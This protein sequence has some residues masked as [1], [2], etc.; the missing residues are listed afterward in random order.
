MGWSLQ[1]FEKGTIRLH[2]VLCDRHFFETS[3]L[4]FSSIHVG[5]RVDGHNN[6]VPE[7][8]ALGEEDGV[9]MLNGPIWH[10]LTSRKQ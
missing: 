9:E 3:I 2:I 7:K 10:G 1:F 6:R 4:P 5:A 8:I